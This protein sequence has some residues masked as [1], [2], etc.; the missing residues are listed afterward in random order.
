MFLFVLLEFVWVRSRLNDQVFRG[1]HQ[2]DWNSAKKRLNGETVRTTIFLFGRSRIMRRRTTSWILTDHLKCS[3]ISHFT[4]LIS[5]SFHLIYIWLDFEWF[6]LKK[7]IPKQQYRYVT[8]WGETRKRAGSRL[9]PAG[10]WWQRRLKRMILQSKLLQMICSCCTTTWANDNMVAFLLQCSIYDLEWQLICWCLIWCREGTG[11]SAA[12]YV[13]Q[14]LPAGAELSDAHGFNETWNC[15][16]TEL[17]FFPDVSQRWQMWQ[18]DQDLEVW[19]VSMRFW[20][21][22]QAFQR[23]HGA[24]ERNQGLADTVRLSSISFQGCK[25]CKMYGWVVIKEANK[26]PSSSSLMILGQS[27]EKLNSKFI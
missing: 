25:M 17:S 13:A 8:T 9:P 7:M 16:C 2:C 3:I 22:W 1:N 18:A 4:N 19:C 10:G 15:I 27:I 11:T 24:G 5:T 14:P 23:S 6:S 26:N 20:C 12:P 21:C